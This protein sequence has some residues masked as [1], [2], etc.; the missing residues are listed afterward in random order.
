MSP[1]EHCLQL[2]PD[3]VPDG[4]LH[5]EDI[6]RVNAHSRFLKCQCE[7]MAKASDVL[8]DR[9]SRDPARE[10]RM[11]IRVFSMEFV[12]I[13]STDSQLDLAHTLGQAGLTRKKIEKE[14]LCQR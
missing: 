2:E 11:T 6:S 12:E 7:C 9:G 10:R 14:T 13:I 5:D 4:G 8:F 3:F 1:S